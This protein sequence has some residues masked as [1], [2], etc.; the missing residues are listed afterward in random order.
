MAATA[1][2]DESVVGDECHII[3]KQSDWSRG[4]AAISEQELDDYP[5]LVL[6][7]KIHHKMVD[8]Q[9][10]TYTVAV[11]KELKRKHEKWVQ[12]T[13]N[14]ASVGK[15]HSTNEMA[16]RITTGKDALAVVFG[17]DAFD[18]DHDELRSEEELEL[19]SGFVQ[20]LRDYG[21]IGMD[22]EAGDRVRFGFALTQDIKHLEEQGFFVFGAVQERTYVVANKPSEMSV[23][24]I[25]IIRKTNPSILKIE[26]P[27]A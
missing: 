5:N 24:V 13:L 8:D 17:A 27:S 2:D 22:V 11:L 9:P 12:E 4:D 19:V 1:R 7:C 15:K 26:S 18:F 25:R 23:A 21:D 14:N 16:I 6:L 3:A 10:N 20:A